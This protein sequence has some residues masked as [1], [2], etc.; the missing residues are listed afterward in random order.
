MMRI[1]SKI[2]KG[3]RRVFKGVLW[4]VYHW[5]Q[6]MFDGSY[7]TFEGVRHRP[8]AKVIA[9]AGDRILVA[10]QKQP[11]TG[12]YYTL[13]GGMMEDG[14]PALS[15]A[16]RELLEEAGMESDDW[17]YFY[18]LSLEPDPKGEHY[19]HVFIARNCVRVAE[20]RIDRGEKLKVMALT[21]GQFGRFIK[22]R[23]HA[24]K[25][26][27]TLKTMKEL[28]EKLRLGR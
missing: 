8:S 26:I 28:R 19:S 12:Y 15:A 7:E 2:P 27:G 6:R 14:E 24:R 3:A 13:L 17:E 10:R 18:T 16:K 23:E 1:K 21:M 4:D 25:Q 22:D 11:N 9:T 5:R 20:P